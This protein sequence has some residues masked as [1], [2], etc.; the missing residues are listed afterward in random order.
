M[1]CYQAARLQQIQTRLMAAW[2][3]KG[4]Q[5]ILN[6]LQVGGKAL[7]S[8]HILMV[9]FRKKERRKMKKKKNVPFTLPLRP[10]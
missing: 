8:L 7:F 9:I 3:D 5:G 6:R 1:G 2:A 4:L 10:T